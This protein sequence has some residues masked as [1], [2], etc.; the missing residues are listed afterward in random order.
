MAQDRQSQ[1]EAL[2]HEALDRPPEERPAFLAR[3][4]G[5]D[6]SLLSEVRSLLGCHEED[7]RFLTLPEGRGL[8]PKAEPRAGKRVGV[9]EL[10]RPIG[11]GGM[12][13]VFLARRTDG[14]YRQDVAIKLVR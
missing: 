13:A 4:C 3:S 12:G 1:L 8:V 9:Y 11:T 6:H 2:F 5:G 10:V 14:A 7:P